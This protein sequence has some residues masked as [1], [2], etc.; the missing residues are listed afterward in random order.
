MLLT[1]KHDKSQKKLC[2]GYGTEHSS[3]ENKNIKDGYCPTQ[4]KRAFFG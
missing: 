2:F 1:T 3:S 4:E